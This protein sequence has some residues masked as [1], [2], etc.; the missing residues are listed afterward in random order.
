MPR[1]YN[2][3]ICANV[4]TEFRCSVHADSF[5]EARRLIEEEEYF[6]VDDSSEISTEYD[7]DTVEYEEDYEDEEDEDEDGEEEEN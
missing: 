6:D 4:Y 2:F 1:W 5:A 7:W 3:T